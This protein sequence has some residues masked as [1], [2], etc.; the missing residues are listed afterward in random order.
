M[1]E[2]VNLSKNGEA[3]LVLC[4]TAESVEFSIRK[5]DEAYRMFSKQIDVVS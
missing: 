1:T 4:E 5:E 3:V 2:Q